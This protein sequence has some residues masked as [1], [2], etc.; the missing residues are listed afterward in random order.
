MELELKK[1]DNF[2]CVCDIGLVLAFNFIRS[3]VPNR[4]DYLSAIELQSQRHQ[5]QHRGRVHCASRQK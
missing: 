3:E 1:S 4:K 2:N 5:Q